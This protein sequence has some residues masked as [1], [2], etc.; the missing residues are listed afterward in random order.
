MN[1][2]S[3]FLSKTFWVQIVTVLS[4]AVP[5]VREWLDANP[6]QFVAVF[7]ALNVIVRFVTSGK[8]NIFGA[9][10]GSSAGSNLILV[11][12]LLGTLVVLGGLPAC[13]AEYPVEGMI[14]YRDA[15]SG[16]KAGLVFSPGH[17]PRASVRV[18]LY[19]TATGEIIGMAALAADLPQVIAEK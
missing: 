16:A 1:T 2:K 13:S 4:L 7:A 9:G 5:Q 18:P 3:I 19:D 17:P 12:V 10:E 11:W 8:I 6:E 15:Q 14:S